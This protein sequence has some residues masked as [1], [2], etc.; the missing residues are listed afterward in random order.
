VSR[1]SWSPGRRARR[2]AKAVFGRQVAARRQRPERV[3]QIVDEYE[4]GSLILDNGR[5]PVRWWVKADNFGDLLSPWL[6][7]KMTGREVRF[8]DPSRAHYLGVGSVLN[9]A[10]ASSTVWGAGSF[11]VEDASAFDPQATY[12]AVRGPLSRA[13]LVNA[14]IECPEVYGDPALLAPAY[15]A[16]KV[17]KRYEYGIV[18]RWLERRWDGAELGPG[19]RLS[20]SR[21]PTWRE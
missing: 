1:R 9:L 18:P 11:G 3:R 8:A 4:V 19:V 21:R 7:S 5:V 10:T 6:V 20:T 16:P 2:L 12:T 17:V 13:R 15:F 14:G